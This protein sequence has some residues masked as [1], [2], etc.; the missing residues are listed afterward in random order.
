ML[1]SLP[2]HI[3]SKAFLDH[4][5]EEAK[6]LNQVLFANFTHEKAEKLVQELSSFLPKKFQKF[7]FSDN[8]STAVEVAL[9]TA[10]Q[11]FAQRGQPQ[12]KSF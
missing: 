4:F 10:I 9:K 6:H 11:S 12:E 7:F 2:A 3:L 5:H 8:G 1:K